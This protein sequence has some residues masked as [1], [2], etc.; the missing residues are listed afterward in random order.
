MSL[1]ASRPPGLSTRA[2]SR[3]TARLS[4]ARLITQLL[5]TQST[6]ASG[7]GSLSMVAMMELDVGDRLATIGLG[8]VAAG[9]FKHLGR[10]V[11][12][13]GLAGRPDLLRRQEHV[14]PA[15]ATEVHHGFAG[16]ETGKGGG[17]A[18]GKPHVR[19]GGDR[20]QLFRRVAECFGDRSDSCVAVESP[21]LATDPYFD[22][23]A[24]SILSDMM[25]SLFGLYP[26]GFT[27]RPMNKMLPVWLSRIRNRNG[28]SARKVG[29]SL[30]EHEPT[31]G[32]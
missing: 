25:I 12:P 17:I 7:R 8:G 15:A 29:G 1:T 27:T 9:Q 19:L 30:V 6:E 23:T 24:R 3:N 18:A 10:H 11:D 5:I 14:Q 2:I 31:W 20:G 26:F 32:P 21:L 28:W 13:D 4:G 16:L 22:C